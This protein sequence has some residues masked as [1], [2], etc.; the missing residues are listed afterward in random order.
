MRHEMGLYSST[1]RAPT[2]GY[3]EEEGGGREEEKGENIVLGGSAG[4]GQE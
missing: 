3:P 4:L 2:E 1:Y